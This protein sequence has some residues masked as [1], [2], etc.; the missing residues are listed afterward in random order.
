MRDLRYAVRVLLKNP[1]FT[2]TAVLTLALCIGANTAIY[3]VVDRVLLRP[4]PYP[5]PERLAMITRHY[6]GGGAS[7]DDLSQSGFTWVALRDGAAGV[8]ELGALSGLGGRVNLVA[9]DRASSVQQERVAAGYFRILG[10]EPEIGREFSAEEDLVNGPAVAVLS[11]A[12]WTRAFGADPSIVG[13]S[14]MLRGEPHT[15]V[16]VM[17]ASVQWGAAIDVWTP[18]RPSIQGEGG[19]ENYGL[20][21][22]LKDGVSWPQALQQIGSATATLAQER[23]RSTRAGTVV[24]FSA[25]PLRRGLTDETRQPLLILWAAVGIVL[26]IGCVNIAG[27]LTARGVARAPEIA[28]RMALGGGRGTIVRQLL[29]ESVVL[30]AC[31]GA[32]GMAIGWAASRLLASWLT[33]AFGVT[34]EIG[35]DARVLTIA[36]GLALLTSIAFGLLPALQASRVDLRGALVESGGTSVAGSARSWPRRLMVTAEVALGVVLLVGAGLMI[37]S[38]DYL[39]GQQPGFDSTNVMTATVSLQDA[40]YRTSDSVARLFDD[41]LLRLRIIPGVEHAA[42]ALTLPYERPLNNGFRL[43]GGPP[44]S[45]IMSMTYVTLGYFEALRIPI[46]RGRVFAPSDGAGS[47]LVII[48]NQAFVRRHSPDDDPIGRQIVSGGVTRTI[49]GIAGD[50]Q[51]KTAF[52]NLGPFGTPPAGFVPESQVSNGFVS[53]AH[54]WFSPSWIVR[55]SAAQEGIVAQMQKAVAT[56]DPLLPVVKFRT[57]DDIRGEA[58]ATPRA[59]AM[60]LST[61]AGLALLLAA[62]GLYGLVANGVAERTRELGIRMALGASSLQTIASAALPGFLLALAGVA[63]G[64]A[65]ARLGASTLRHLVW[66]VSV[67]DPLTFTVAIGVV[68]IVAAVAALV[69]ALRIVRLN[70]IKALRAG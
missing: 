55:L 70:P 62:V 32:A 42:A 22:R 28:T 47:P 19:G 24:R 25:V 16:G 9:G 15:V 18:L 21:A 11:H 12:L 10:I 57:L 27:L 51:Q 41:T 37:R 64:G 44:E 36:T 58:V 26:L 30:A 39:M 69:P 3:T 49:V 56:V 2:L 29:T 67:A 61:L 63:I 13:R 14:I 66:G 43:V 54:T 35:L 38:F 60:L 31:G 53:M 4:L 17:P 45:R 33:A 52:G 1:A 7:E 50:V 68:L 34:G 65:A 8:I 23:Y 5:H 6:E 48:V 40:R 46:V 20:I 59:Q